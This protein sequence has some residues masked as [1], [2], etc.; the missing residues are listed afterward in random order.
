MSG[1]PIVWKSGSLNLLET[2]SACPGLYK[3]EHKTTISIKM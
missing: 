1:N 3:V 2:H